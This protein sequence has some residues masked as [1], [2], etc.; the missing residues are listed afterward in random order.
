MIICLLEVFI[1]L[2]CFKP[3]IGMDFDGIQEQQSLFVCE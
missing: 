1:P 2:A 3:L